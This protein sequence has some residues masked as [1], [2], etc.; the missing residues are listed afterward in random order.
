[1]NIGNRP[2][3]ETQITKESISIDVNGRVNSRKKPRGAGA[4]DDG[5]VYTCSTKRNGDN[6]FY[7]YDDCINDGSNLAQ[8][9]SYDNGAEDA[10]FQSIDYYRNEENFEGKINFIAQKGIINGETTDKNNFIYNEGN[11]LYRE[12][13]EKHSING[14]NDNVNGNGE[15]GKLGFGFYKKSNNFYNNHADKWTKELTQVRQL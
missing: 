10:M 1:M 3:K 12:S 4:A 5:F 15:D 9:R 2:K 13:V 11:E 14:I 6:F 7:R 8:T